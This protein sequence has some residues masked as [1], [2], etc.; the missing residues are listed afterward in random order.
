MVAPQFR[1]PFFVP[2]FLPN[3]M[4]ESEFLFLQAHM[5]VPQTMH[6]CESSASS[7]IA[8]P[9]TS[10]SRPCGREAALEG[11]LGKLETDRGGARRVDRALPRVDVRHH[12][13][14]RER[15]QHRQL[16]AAVSQWDPLVPPAR[17]Q[18]HATRHFS[19]GARRQRHTG[20]AS[21]RSAQARL[22]FA[23]R[24]PPPHTS[25]PQGRGSP[26]TGPLQG[27]KAAARPGWAQQ[28]QAAPGKWLM[29]MRGCHPLATT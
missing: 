29:G 22:R 4:K 14:G 19:A 11:L 5:K 7:T 27:W 23:E 3:G 28:R 10:A 2:R 21:H 20:L 18:A 24:A 12:R 8:D 17:H 26:P 1:S 15:A 16:S 13:V 25:C 9:A 6:Q